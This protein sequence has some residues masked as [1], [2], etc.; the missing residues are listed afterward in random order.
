MT[1]ERAAWQ[2]KFRIVQGLVILWGLLWIVILYFVIRY[3]A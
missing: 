2:R 1:P 3:A